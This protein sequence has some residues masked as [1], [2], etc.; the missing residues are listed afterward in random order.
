M[1][2]PAAIASIIAATLLLP[3]TAQASAPLVTGQLTDDA[4]RPVIGP[5]VVHAWPKERGAPMPVVASAVANDRGDFTATITDPEQLSAVAA[6][7]NGWVDFLAV[8]GTGRHTG[9][10]AFTSRIARA[11]G[12]LRSVQVRDAIHSGGAR[13][14]T[15]G[16]PPRI[17]LTLPRG[18]SLSSPV[19][20]PASITGRCNDRNPERR[21]ARSVSKW[22]VIGELNNAYSDT[23]AVFHYGR[24]GHAETSIGVAISKD[25]E[26]S[27]TISGETHVSKGGSIQFP[28]IKRRYARKLRTK[29]EYTREQIRVTPCSA[30]ET[31]IRATDWLGG[32]DDAIKQP[33]TLNK[34]DSTWVGGTDQRGVDN[35]YTGHAV[36]WNRGVTVFGVHLTTK[37]GFSENVGLTYRYGTSRPKY[38]LCGPDGKQGFA[39]APRVFS[40]AR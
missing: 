31:H 29:F 15:A 30:W 23:R 20:G 33:G 13:A 5:V 17:R 40:G 26:A 35:K 21:D 37:S 1:N 22:T 14:A 3:A 2:R 25:N 34:C 18:R 19:A 16:R 36:R 27:F 7:E 12:T 11:G 9:Q 10:W 39:G 28:M 24:H 32:T 6:D 8:S 38:Y 4:G